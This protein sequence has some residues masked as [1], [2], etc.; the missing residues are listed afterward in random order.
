MPRAHPTRKPAALTVRLKAQAVLEG[1]MS[2]VA[3]VTTDTFDS[4]VGTEGLALVDFWAP[5][6]GPC[7]RIGPII[8]QLADEMG[9]VKFGKINTD[10]NQEAAV[11][12]GVQ[13]IPTLMLY[14]DGQK[15]DTLVGAHP[16]ET[17]QQL[18]AKHS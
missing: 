16:K 14:K 7:K 1:R 9:E 15:V 2:K 6:C 3:E 12:H 13:G 17:L 5:W 8:E 10:D 18:I 4:F 11:A